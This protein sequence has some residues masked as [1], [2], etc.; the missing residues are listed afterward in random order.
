MRLTLLLLSLVV[1]CAATTAAQS[2]SFST[3]P[4]S[5]TQEGTVLAAE[6]RDVW[7]GISEA[8]NAWALQIRQDQEF[9]NVN[10]AT[11]A[12]VKAQAEK[13]SAIAALR[14]GYSYFSGDG[15]E[16]DFDKAYLWLTKA[17]GAHLAPADFLLGIAS[18]NGL[19]VNQDFARAVEFLDRSAEQG[20]ALAEFQLG[21][22]YLR[23]GPGV[24]QAPARGIKWLTRAAEQGK[25]NAQQFLAWCYA[26][27]IGVREDPAQAF[28]W[29]RKAAGQ[30]SDTAQ[31]LF[32]MFWA[33]A[34][35]T[36][37]NWTE[38]A[39]WF[40]LAANQGLGTA[41]MHLA[42]CYR[43][44]RGV[45]INPNEAFHWWQKAAEQRFP[46]AQFHVGLCA[47]DG[48]GTARDY[49]AATTWFQ[50]AAQQQH[51]GAEL[52]LGLCFWKGRGVDADVEL[53][54]KWW[55][56]AAVYGMAER[57]SQIGDDATE[58]EKWWQQ[59]AKEGNAR[60]QCCLAEFYRFGLGVAPNEAE[61]L[62][63][64]RK[65]SESGDPAALQAAAWLLATSSKSELRDGRSAVELATKAA[66]VTK[67]KNP[68]TL[69][70]LAAA[71][72]EAAQFG[73]AVSVENEAIALAQEDE[74]KRD[75]QS[76]L[77]LY[78]AKAP[79]RSPEQVTP[80]SQLE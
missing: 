57:P 65:A 39:K 69:D 63:W 60:I 61:A 74:E 66:T 54:E 32:G 71:Y 68:K 31:D 40:G 45:A 24:N 58:V 33:T 41:E 22:C 15:L 76:R 52:Y 27:G 3:P 5:E 6:L 9:N 23:G 10:R 62:K 67:R 56:E 35:G 34:Y 46:S 16:R 38:A 21:L 80:S 79:Y 1:G 53:A 70:T 72:A 18:L 13:G 44:G 42:Q 48:L 8:T 29:C 43:V 20:F 14:L 25:P 2:L 75:Y 51:V 12:Q 17:A 73:K 77:K 50:K 7:P 59:V 36:N 11:S 19:G 4:F 28:E 78:Q 26:S 37:Q 30:G 55:R 49:A 47:Y 64:Y